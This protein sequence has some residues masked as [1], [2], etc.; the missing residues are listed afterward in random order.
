MVSKVVFALSAAALLGVAALTSRQARA[1]QEAAERAY[2]PEGVFVDVDGRKVHAH[3]QGSGPDLILIH[4]AGGNTREWSFSLMS[5]LA[6]NYRVI[7]FDRPGLGYSDRA[8]EKYEKTITSEAESPF[9]QA[10]MLH[11]AAQKLGVERAIIAG[12][13]FGGTIALAWALD[14]PDQVAGLLNL[15]GPSHPWPGSLGAYYRVNGS[16]VGG[17]ISPPFLAAFTG[18]AKIDDAI[19][20]IFHPQPVPDGY[21]DHIGAPLTLR[22]ESM[23]ANTRQ[24]N[25]LYPHIEKMAARYHELTLPIIVIHGD[26]DETVPLHIHAEPF[27]RDVPH[28]QLQVL[29]GVGHMPHHADPNAVIAAIDR[30]AFESGLRRAP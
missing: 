30:L 24:V 10:H 7:A 9:E 23:R 21:G 5:K 6:A 16:A 8:H 17:A 19:K 3:I 2:P 27:A 13:S 15:A 14:F 28:A 25:G 18:T 1:Q 12:H 11:L 20:A 26:Q 22:A 29:P 4:G